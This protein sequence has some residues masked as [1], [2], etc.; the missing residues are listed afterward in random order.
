MNYVNAFLLG[1]LTIVISWICTSANDDSSMEINRHCQGRQDC[2]EFGYWCDGNMTCQCAGMYI[3][4]TDKTRCLGGVRQKC[5]YD[6]DCI[7]NAFCER[8]TM[9]RCKRKYHP[10]DGGLVCK[11]QVAD[12]VTQS[13]SN[14]FQ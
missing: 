8:Q 1:I 12:G 4:N 5:L 13:S 3:A 2:P 6:D 9:C 14:T 10:S 7:K 11:I